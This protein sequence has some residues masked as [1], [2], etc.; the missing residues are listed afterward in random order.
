VKPRHRPDDV[1]GPIVQ[2]LRDAQCKVM[3]LESPDE[4]EPDVLVGR[5]GTLTL[6]EFKSRDGRLSEEQRA[7]HDA[8]ARVG[9]RVA[10]VRSPREALDAVGIT[11]PRAGEN[12]AAMRSLVSERRREEKAR[13][14]LRP[15]VRR[16]A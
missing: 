12:L 10:V 16:P 14:R 1:A 9:V 2:M 7:A 4:G 13:G 3:P 15:A 5:L 11:G 6:I 8:W